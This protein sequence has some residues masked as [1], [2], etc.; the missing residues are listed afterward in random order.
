MIIID[1]HTTYNLVHVISVLF[2][3]SMFYNTVLVGLHKYVERSLDFGINGPLI[4]AL[5]MLFN[6]LLS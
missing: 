1:Q 2:A 6:V 5:F 4:Y 3:Y